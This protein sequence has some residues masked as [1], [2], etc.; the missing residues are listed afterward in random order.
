MNLRSVLLEAVYRHGLCQLS[1]EASRAAPRAVFPVRNLLRRCTGIRRTSSSSL[2]LRPSIWYPGDPGSSRLGALYI[3]LSGKCSL[4][5]VDSSVFW[6]QNVRNST[7]QASPAAD[8]AEGEKAKANVSK[9]QVS[10]DDLKSL[11]A[12]GKVTLVDVREPEELKDVGGLPGCTN[13]PLTKLKAAL[14]LNDEEFKQAYC[15]PKFQK[16]DAGV[17]FYGLSSVKSSA[18]V[19]IAHKMG[20][21]KSRHYPGGL[22]EWNKK[23]PKT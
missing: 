19:E 15:K 1:G 8:V 5:D 23:N 16:D 20:F 18:A 3:G 12:S 4:T 7:T 11:I 9:T 17:V 10:F 2:V 21:K 13:I 22:E 14:A 6:G